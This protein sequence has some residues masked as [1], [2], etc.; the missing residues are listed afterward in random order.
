MFVICWLNHETILI[1]LNLAVKLLIIYFTSSLFVTPA[2]LGNSYL[3]S[4]PISFYM[5]TTIN[6]LKL[7][8][9]LDGVKFWKALRPNLCF[10]G[11]IDTCT[12]YVQSCAPKSIAGEK[13]ENLYPNYLTWTTFQLPVQFLQVQITTTKVEGRLQLIWKCTS[14]TS[15]QC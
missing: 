12:I 11:A 9:G 8:P 4:L 10:V 3:V 13:S 14:M 6:I 1:P 2:E 15:F 7:T 5:L